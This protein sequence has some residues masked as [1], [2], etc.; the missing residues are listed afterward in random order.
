MKRVLKICLTVIFG[1]SGILVG[2]AKEEEPIV[3][4]Q[5]ELK[6]IGKKS[7]GEDVYSVTIT[8]LTNK[9]IV[10]FAIKSN[11]MKDY[12]NN[13]LEKNDTFEKEEDRILYYDASEAIKQNNE[14]SKNQKMQTSPEYTIQLT[15]DDESTSELHAFPFGDCEIVTIKMDEEVAYIEYTSISQNEEISTLEAEK[16]IHDETKKESTKK[17]SQNEETN[18]V[19]ES[20]Y[21]SSSSEDSNSQSYAVEEPVQPIVQEPVQPEV[22]EPVQPDVPSSS[23]NDGCLGDNVETW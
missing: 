4:K 15:F 17:E 8:N 10:S 18:D 16:K 5:E 1:L 6:T 21:V 23:A 7:S 12:E 3:E 22:V 20:T 9:D 11:T 14:A 19:E 13:M 2:C